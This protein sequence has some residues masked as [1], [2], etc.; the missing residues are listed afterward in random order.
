MVGSVRVFNGEGMD[1]ELD[2]E[3][4]KCGRMFATELEADLCAKECETR[5]DWTGDI[6]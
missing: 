5:T 4:E 3:C 1:K 2:H 6:I